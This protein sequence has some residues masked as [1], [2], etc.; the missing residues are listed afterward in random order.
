M[1][2]ENLFPPGFLIHRYP[3]R[4]ILAE[5]KLGAGKRRKVVD[6]MGKRHYNI[7]IDGGFFPIRGLTFPGDV[8]LLKSVWRK[9]GK[10]CGRRV[11][12]SRCP[13]D[14]AGSGYG[15]LPLYDPAAV[16]GPGKFNQS[17]G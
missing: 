2:R 7:L 4:A 12:D 8:G 13:T 11:K 3:R 10:Y 16:C 17:G 1:D 5:E 15:H 6:Y 14:A 9:N